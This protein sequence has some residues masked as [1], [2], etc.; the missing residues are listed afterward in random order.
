MTTVAEK[1]KS[2]EK[3]QLGHLQAKISLPL[4]RRVRRLAA[5]R[6]CAP[7]DVVTHALEKYLPGEEKKLQPA[8]T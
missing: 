5:D 7:R 6:G 8:G 2:Q 4:L 1:V 3:P